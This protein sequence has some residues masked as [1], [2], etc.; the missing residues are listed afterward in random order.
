VLYTETSEHFIAELF[1]ATLR[2]DG[3]TSRIHKELSTS[4]YLYQFGDNSENPMFKF[5]SNNSGLK[6]ILLSRVIDIEKV[7]TRFSFDPYEIHPTK[8]IMQPEGGC[9]I[10]FG[11][12]FQSCFLNNCLI[13]NNFQQFYR[14]K[15]ILYVC[16]VS[17]SLALNT[18]I[19]EETNKH[20]WPVNT[21]DD[22]VGIH[23]VPSKA[24]E[25]YKLSG[26]F[27]N[28]FLVPDIRE[29]N[30]G[31]FLHRNPDILKKALNCSEFLY[32]KPFKWLEGNP[33]PSEDHIQPDFVLK[34][35]QS[36]FWDICDIKKPLLDKDNLTKGEHS[37]RRFK[38][39]VYEGI[40]QLANYEQYFSYPENAK[41]AKVKYG[42][43]INSPKLILIIGNYEN[44]DI[45]QLQEASRSLKDNYTV[46]DYDSLNVAYLARI[47]KDIANK[48]LN[49]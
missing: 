37:R 14:M 47:K 36:L 23:Y 44:F 5:D 26:Q 33:N 43:E 28:I 15:D 7:K 41:Y 24:V 12:N 8:M 40:A 6:N 17:K 18:F 16:I 22:L 35:S 19:R 34:S 45:Q 49:N 42:V 46:I 13:I 1:G 10:S 11:T 32:E 25:S 39:D 20:Q 2:F 21:T 31:K 30:I 29:P 9:L 38:D 3:L 27:A 4:R 48:N